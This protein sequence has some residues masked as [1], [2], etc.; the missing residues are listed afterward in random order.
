MTLRRDPI[1]AMAVSGLIIALYAAPALGQ[2]HRSR[3][4]RPAPRI[5]SVLW[6]D[7][8][9]NRAPS[10]TRPLGVALMA[11]KGALVSNRPP[12]LM[13]ALSSVPVRRGCIFAD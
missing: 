9:S 4:P 12:A 1:S 13:P 6:T 11:P 5:Q 8:K 2:P 10:G 3:P 7:N